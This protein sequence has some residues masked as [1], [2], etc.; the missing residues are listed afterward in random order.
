MQLYVADVGDGL[1]AGIR[2]LSGSMLQVDCGSQPSGSPACRYGL[3]RILP[4]SFFLS[5]FHI[6]HYNGLFH[7]GADRFDIRRAFFPRLPSFPRREQFMTFMLAVAYRVMGSTS[8]SMEADFLSAVRGIATGNFWY[9]SLS[10]GD[11]VDVEGSHF[12]VLWPPKTVDDEEA[13]A[14]VKKAIIDSESALEGDPELRRLYE[15][16][17]NS[18]AVEPYIREGVEEVPYG[19]GERA[20]VA[21]PSVEPRT[22]P[23]VVVRANNSLRRAANHMSLALYEDN[24][25]LFLGDLEE[26]ELERVS[27]ELVGKGRT[28]FLSTITPHHGT[29]WHDSLKQIKTLYAVSSIGKKLIGNFRPEFKSFGSRCLATYSNGEIHIPS[30][31]A[32]SYFDP[33]L[34]W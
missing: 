9:R 12:E 3:K 34:G 30:P 10:A 17:Q 27:A 29:H 31:L 28:T 32:W 33:T 14:A 8:G 6:D 20:P 26:Q 7:V 1:A 13:S 19:R 11:T 16:L 22:L 23:Q 25:F 4:H 5:H 21:V 15:E 24:R 18:A 2:T